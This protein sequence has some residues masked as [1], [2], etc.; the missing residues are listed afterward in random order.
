MGRRPKLNFIDLTEFRAI[1]SDESNWIIYKRGKLEKGVGYSAW[2]AYSFH[3]EFETAVIYLKKEL[4]R[5]AEVT[6]FHALVKAAEEIKA[7][8]DAKLSVDVLEVVGVE[9]KSK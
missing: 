3:P 2:L 1:G 9:K 4:L 5:M 6:T 7:L 8:M